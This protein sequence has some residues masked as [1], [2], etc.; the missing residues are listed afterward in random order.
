M[1]TGTG[2]KAKASGTHFL[3]TSLELKGNI[4]VCS[5]EP[6]ASKRVRG[7]VWGHNSRKQEGPAIVMA[8]PLLRNT[9]WVFQEA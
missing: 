8:H 5:T 7:R 6:R 4:S 2:E 9:T 1:R 3:R